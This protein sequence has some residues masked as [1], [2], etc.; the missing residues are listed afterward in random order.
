MQQQYK[1]RCP[2]AVQCIVEYNNN[3]TFSY[4]GKTITQEAKDF[5][6]FNF[7]HQNIRDIIN[8]CIEPLV[9]LHEA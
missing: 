2:S 9:I 3:Y 1:V 8:E 7:L 6:P 4:D 5:N